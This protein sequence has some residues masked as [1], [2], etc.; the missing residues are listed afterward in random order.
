MEDPPPPAPLKHR[1]RYQ[2]RRHTRAILTSAVGESERAS[3]RVSTLTCLHNESRVIRLIPPHTQGAAAL[4]LSPI[5]PIADRAPETDTG[6]TAHPH[7]AKRAWV[8][9]FRKRRKAS[10]WIGFYGAPAALKRASGGLYAF[11]T[12]VDTSVITGRLLSGAHRRPSTRM[13][14]LVAWAAVEDR[15]PRHHDA[16]QPCLSCCSA[17]PARQRTIDLTK[18][19]EGCPF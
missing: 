9:S 2:T 19:A 3:V 17:S 12:M 13:P 8:G 1:R 6:A 18:E 10:G 15:A 4:S 11:V 14:P 5:A 16:V 7:L